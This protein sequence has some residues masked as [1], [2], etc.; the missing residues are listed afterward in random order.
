MSKKRKYANS[1]VVSVV[2]DNDPKVFEEELNHKLRDLAGR[3][4]DIAPVTPFSGG[5]G[6]YISHFEDL[7][8]SDNKAEVSEV[9]EVRKSRL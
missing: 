4:I 1:I 3:V 5:F 8:E 7:L 9:D 6:A 2:H